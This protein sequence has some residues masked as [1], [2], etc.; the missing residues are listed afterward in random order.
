ML[1]YLFNCCFF[2]FFF[3][4]AFSAFT[5]YD[6]DHLKDNTQITFDLY[7]VAGVNRYVGRN[8]VC[9]VG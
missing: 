4:F 9:K 3:F 2:F 7:R 1:L 5:G 6:W 8:V